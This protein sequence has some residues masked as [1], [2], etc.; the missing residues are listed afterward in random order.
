M[1]KSWRSLT[2]STLLGA[3]GYLLM[4]IAIPIVPIAPY[5]KLDF[6]GIPI[7]LAFLVFGQKEGYVS[8]GIKELLHLIFEGMSVGNLIGVLADAMELIILAEIVYFVSKGGRKNFVWAIISSTL[9]ATIV[10]SA[11][12]YWIITPLYMKVIGM[13]ITIPL[14][15]LVLIGVVPHNLIK[16]V[17][18]SGLTLLLLPRLRKVLVSQ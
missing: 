11:A 14:I 3:I 17:L 8:L 10:M 12:N 1:G 18:I 4:Y 13:K 6:S 5:M 7:L 16:G 2:I 9:V 15:K